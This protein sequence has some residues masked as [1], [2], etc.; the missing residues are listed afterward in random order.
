MWFLLA[1]SQSGHWLWGENERW[2]TKP[3]RIE[4]WSWSVSGSFRRSHFDGWGYAL[5][6]QHWT[7]MR[8]HV[9]VCTQ[10][11]RNM[12]QIQTYLVSSCCT[13]AQTALPQHRPNRNTT[14][15][16]WQAQTPN[17][18]TC[19]LCHCFHFSFRSLPPPWPPGLTF[20]EGFL[21]AC[22]T[23][24]PLSCLSHATE[25]LK[26]NSFS[27]IE[28][29]DAPLP[30][31]SC[32]SLSLFIPS[33]SLPFSQLKRLQIRVVFLGFSFANRKKRQ[34]RRGRSCQSSSELTTRVGL[35]QINRT[36]PI[37]DFNHY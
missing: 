20:T 24:C 21:W 18:T 37:I 13:A 9:P 23:L 7:V 32:M 36:K 14:C 26:D 30:P 12:Q 8:A 25:P 17:N 29:G 16:V 34:A 2:A 27:G 35:G 31:S 11:G 15:E 3:C 4:P 5:G 28:L 19:S 33:S 6:M 22:L 10:V 1:I